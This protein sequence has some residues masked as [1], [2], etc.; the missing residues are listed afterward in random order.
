MRELRATGVVKVLGGARVLRGVDAS[1][2]GGA[3]HVVEGANGSGKSTLLAVLGGR[4]TA[5]SG[6]CEL[7]EDGTRKLG[8]D[9]RAE[10]GWL[11]HELGLYPDLTAFENVALHARLRG[12]D[13][14]AIWR[15][16]ASELGVEGVAGRRV[17][18]LSRG[19]RQRVALV[20]AL[21][22]GPP[23]LLLDEPST[24]LDSST[25]ERLV[26]LLL[27]LRDI[28]VIVLVV[29]HD[30]PFRNELLQRPNGASMAV[31]PLAMLW[32]LVSGR[33]SR[34]AAP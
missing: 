24:G 32:K 5:T 18:E 8:K 11:G 15:L 16:R 4:A 33:L 20:R 21:V 6:R 26:R 25:T 2:E 19:Q 27:G 22:G 23:V 13:A 17:R 9:L 34:E 1:F 30:A 10:V 3:L 29:T 7:I 12:D 14:D 31:T 28:G